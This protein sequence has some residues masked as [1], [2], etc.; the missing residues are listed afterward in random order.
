MLA[1]TQVV[2]G[3]PSTAG[4]KV[5]YQPKLTT[6]PVFLKLCGPRKIAPCLISLVE[7]NDTVTVKFLTPAKDPKWRVGTA[8]LPVQLRHPVHPG[9]GDPGVQR[10]IKGS[11]LT[12]VTHVIFGGAT[13]TV[14]S[15]TATQIVAVVPQNAQTG[16]ITLTR[17]TGSVA[18]PTQI[19]VT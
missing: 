15:H 19:K 8:S 13:A 11:N 16:L 18:S 1:I 2:H 10:T 7:Q 6:P 17:N 12:P 3:L 9:L 5:C 4:V 14:R